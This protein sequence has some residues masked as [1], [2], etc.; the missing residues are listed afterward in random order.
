MIA[1][2]RRASASRPLA[3]LASAW[4]LTMGGSSLARPAASADKPT[5]TPRV[6]VLAKGPYL[7]GLSTTTVTIKF[8]LA[9]PEAAR[10]EVVAAGPGDTTV[11][12]AEAGS[13]SFHALRVTGLRPA[14]TYDYRVISG[15]AV[16]SAGHF[17]TAP[18]DV[19]PF[20]FLVYGDNRSNVEAHSA[21]VRAMEKAQGDFL[22]NTGDLVA[23]GNNADDWRSFFA[24]EGTL[25][26]DRCVF[27]SVG[28]HELTRGDSAGEVAFLRY[29]A[30]EDDGPS[31][32]RLYGSFRWSNTRFFILNAMDTWTGDEHAWLRA[33]LDRAAG[34]P[35]LMHRIAV[36]HWSPFS[37]GLH[38]DNLALSR[39]GVLETMRSHHVDLILAGHDH[40]YERGEGEGLKYVISGGGG[41]PLYPKAR[42]EAASRHFE[43]VHHFVEVL[44]DGDRV[45]LT[46]RAVS[47]AVM[48]TCGF[49]GD[50]GWDCDAATGNTA[51]AADRTKA[52]T[53]NPTFAPARA[54]RGC[55]CDLSG[56]NRGGTPSP[57]APAVAIAFGLT[58]LGRRKLS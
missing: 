57:W 38:G 9:T 16:S 5:A 32:G 12:K 50:S 35:G 24:I 55:A 20:R 46:A 58:L 4:I 22:V 15:G 27:A 19:R 34:E 53:P 7:Q 13:R 41:A 31:K 49:R 10:V 28:N 43:S 21:V 37:S 36:L 25:L 33:E 26:R 51:A 40:A 39:A 44:V 11:A 45:S 47:G 56:A 18:D 6:L 42:R 14:T 48:E 8:E 3:F 23:A 17:T 54:N 52:E 2:N 30:R 1:K 29:F